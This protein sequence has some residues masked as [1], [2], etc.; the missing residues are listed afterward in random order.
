MTKNMHHLVKINLPGGIISSGNLLQVLR[1]AHT[2]GI[3]E[4]SFGHRQHLL[5]EASDAQ[6]RELQLHLG[7][8][9]IEV[10]ADDY[11][12]IMSSYVTDEVFAPYSWLSE[13]VYKDI[14]YSFN[15]APRLKINI[16]DRQQNLI[17]FFTGN[18]NFISSD[19][20]NHWYLYIRFPKTNQ[21][22]H[23]PSLIYSGD[24]AEFSRLI[25]FIILSEHHLFYN[26]LD[27]DGH[28]LVE[29]LTHKASF[30]TQ[31][32][33]QPL[34]HTDF[35][36]PFYE[37]INTYSEQ[38][39]WLGI[40]RRKESFP[41]EFLMALCSLCID[42]RI[43][44]LY[45]TP[46]KSLLIKNIL[47]ID[48]IHWTTLLNKYRMNVRHASNELNWQLEDRC[49]EALDLKWKLVK[50]FEE[51]DLRTSRLCFAI[52]TTKQTGLFGS[53][54]IQKEKTES[55]DTLYQVMHTHNFNPNSKQFVHYGSARSTQDLSRLLIDLCHFYYDMHSDLPQKEEENEK[56]VTVNENNLVMIYECSH[57]LTQYDPS[58]GDPQQEIPK[59]TS[60]HLLNAYNCPTCDATLSDFRP[61][62]AGH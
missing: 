35:Q 56:D 22:F 25:E 2:L 9:T 60:F 4:L 40:Y 37:G 13:G 53:I 52:K 17:P 57:C 21:M 7:N 31:P 19:I 55:G 11:P 8:N 48:R 30:N 58:Y 12:N 46:W 32:F 54:V 44:Q 3:T 28:L 20:N 45:T 18:L 59:G 43:G 47:P 61:V 1:L 26:K 16:V 49:Q 62:H 14:L 51:A 36:L 29:K 27:A 24:I 38:K 6:I 15:Y 50:A 23:W 42:S 33:L 39:L 10:N 5:L 34:I 41:I